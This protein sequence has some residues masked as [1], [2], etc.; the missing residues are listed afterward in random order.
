MTWIDEAVLV[1]NRI[2]NEQSEN[3]EKAA[4]IAADAIG[5]GGVVH[6][7]GTGHSRIPVEEMF[8]RYGSF[9][10]FHPIVELSMTFHT[11]IS[12]ANGQR[13]AMFI[14][15]VPGL[16]EVILSNFKLRPTD[17]IMIFSAS[18]RNAVP[19]ETAMVAKA[20]GLKVIAV[21]SGSESKTVPAT[22]ASGTTLSDHAD[23][24]IDLC[25]P[26]GDAAVSINGWSNKVGPVS[27][28]AN[29]AIV[30]SLKVLTA[31]KLADRGIELPVLTGAQI[32][33]RE[34]SEELFENAYLEHA[35]R[36]SDVLRVNA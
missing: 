3:I 22:H 24:V 20:A 21:T 26:L 1:L 4:V 23:V 17:A 18:G 30:N 27:T 8:P 35:K 7:F 9:P 36:K 6:T 16:A 14:E 19:V 31:Q 15:R 5:G 25:T 13:Q 10:G 29:V 34:V 28:V 12:G 11:E 33:G 2:Q 32:V